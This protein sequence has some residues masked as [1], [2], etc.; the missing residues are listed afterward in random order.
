M[1]EDLLS[2]KQQL[3]Q[4]GFPE[5]LVKLPQKAQVAW[6]EAGD[7]SSDFAVVLLHGISSGAASW[8]D[9]ALQ[10]GDKARVLAW[11][12]P[13]YGVSTPLAQSAPADADYVQVLAQSLLVLGVR[14]CLLVGH[15]L[16]ALM[17]ARL[18]VTA[19]PGLVEQLV[20]ISP[21]GGYGAPAKAEQQAKVREGRLAALAEKGVAGLAAVIDQRLVSS[22]APEAVR[23]WVRWNT[24][25]M[26]PQGYAQAVELLCG[27]DLAQA[28]GRLGMPVE[29]W[30]G[31]H[32]V[33]TTPAACKSWSELLGAHYGTL[34]AA[35][36]ASPVEQPM[37]VAHRLA[38]LLNQSYCP[39]TS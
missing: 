32:D 6:R 16:G 28:R 13:G 2:L 8:L 33:V 27:S 36:H 1:H 4:T 29:V 26:Q 39:N 20:L 23:A 9:V 31:E 18:A 30:V 34:A 22:E 35:G 38:S 19:A 11:D 14:R 21:A 37:E 7:A 15:S 12:A 3:L 17:A 24:A 25:R 5:R 10:L